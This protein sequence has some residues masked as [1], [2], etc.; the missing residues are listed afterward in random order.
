[1]SRELTPVGDFLALTQSR[2]AGGSFTTGHQWV[3]LEGGGFGVVYL[4]RIG[5]DYTWLMFERFDA[6][7]MLIGEPTRIDESRSVYGVSS[8]SVAID[9]DGDLLVSWSDEFGVYGRYVNSNGTLESDVFEIFVPSDAPK[10]K[11]GLDIAFNA[12]GNLIVTWQDYRNRTDDPTRIQIQVFD[13]NGVP[14]AAAEDVYSREEGV[15]RLDL[16]QL[17]TGAMVITW[18]EYYRAENGAWEI[19]IMGQSYAPDGTAS[20]DVFVLDTEPSNLFV[21]PNRSVTALP[22]GK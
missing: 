2:G 12:S 15:A 10:I 16:V 7:Q 11:V 14:I 22:D 6:N 20:G 21:E 4:R 18:R 19:A 9:L 1:M 5:I 3:D 17:D 13:P 8:Q